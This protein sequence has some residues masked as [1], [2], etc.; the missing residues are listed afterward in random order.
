MLLFIVSEL[1]DDG[2]GGQEPRFSC[3][4]VYKK[5]REFDMKAIMMLSSVMRGMSFWTA[6]SLTLSQDRPTDPSYLFNLSNVTEEG[7]S[8]QGT[9]LET[10]SNIV[11]V[12][13]F[14][15]ENQELNL[16]TAEDVSAKNKYGII[17]KKLQDLVVVQ[18]IKQED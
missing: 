18:E 13:Y 11:S 6:G 4:T 15:M 14:D 2:N 7:F 16:K 5:E 12:S 1:V 8:Y 10:R 17:Q 3:N 9:K